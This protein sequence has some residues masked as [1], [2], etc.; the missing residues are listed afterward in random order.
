M[1]RGRGGGGSGMGVFCLVPIFLQSF[2]F[3]HKYGFCTADPLLF[4]GTLRTSSI[5]YCIS[6]VNGGLNL[7]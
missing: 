3:T 2:V 5:L 1:G 6:Y 7:Y 4:K